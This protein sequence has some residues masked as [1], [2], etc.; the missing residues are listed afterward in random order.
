MIQLK[1]YF[2]R[3]EEEY[4]MEILKKN[5]YIFIQNKQSKKKYI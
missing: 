5:K 1:W 2:Y 4:L 3:V